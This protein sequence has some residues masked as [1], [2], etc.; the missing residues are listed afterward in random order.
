[1]CRKRSA[2]AQPGWDAHVLERM[3]EVLFTPR[4]TL[5]SRNILQYY[6]DLGINGP[7]FLWA[8]L[9]PALEAYSEHPFVKKTEGGM[10]T[11]H[12]ISWWR[13]AS[14]CCNSRWASY[15]A[16]MNCKRRR[17]GRGESIELDAV[18]QYYLAASARRSAWS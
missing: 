7:D 11:V 9:G 12:G 17:K 15:R 13:C 8:A 1:M 2:L 16:F 5:G 10:M 14:W 4:Q 3:R 18:T 6:F